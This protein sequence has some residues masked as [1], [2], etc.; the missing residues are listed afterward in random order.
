M[1]QRRDRLAQWAAGIIC[2][3]SELNVNAELEI[4]S[5]DASFRRYFRL[6]HNQSSWV[7][8][9]A[10]ADKEDNPRFI[11]IARSW[12]DQGVAVPKVIDQDIN[13]GF[14]LLEDFGD[15][16]LWP[17]LHDSASEEQVKNL[18]S[19]AIDQLLHIQ[20]LN[21]ESLPLYDKAL[22]DQEM[23]LFSDW[24]CDKQLELVLSDSEQAMLTGVFELLRERALA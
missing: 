4:V 2:Q 19:L 7:A 13:Q 11:R 23:S 15:R 18:Y 14:M 5:G 22:L 16:L 21:T 6:Y 12:Y 8:V 20:Q 3:Q 1:D 17:A 24:L 9:D 10:P